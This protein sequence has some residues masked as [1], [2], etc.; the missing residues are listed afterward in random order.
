MKEDVLAFAHGPFRGAFESLCCGSLHHLCDVLPKQEH[1]LG[2]TLEFSDFC[3]P[4]HGNN[5]SDLGLVARREMVFAIN[6]TLP[7]NVKP[8]PYLTY[9]H[10]YARSTEE[11]SAK[12]TIR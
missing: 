4:R 3:S 5:P 8:Q 2:G 7:Y 12:A 1:N 9:Y 6:T 11:I 10:T